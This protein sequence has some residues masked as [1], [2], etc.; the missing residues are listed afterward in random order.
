MI[1][2]SGDRLKADPGLPSTIAVDDKVLSALLG[3]L[4]DRNLRFPAVPVFV[5]DLDVFEMPDGLGFQFR[6]VEAPVILRGAKVAAVVRYLRSRLDGHSTIQRVL[7]DAPDEV[8]AR[9]LVRGLL[10]LHSKG[11][12]I[13]A[14]PEQALRINVADGNRDLLARER[15]YWQRHLGVTRSASSADEVARRVSAARLVVV[16]TGMFGAA[17]V[18]LL[19]RSGFHKCEVVAWNDD[20]VMQQSDADGLAG[21]FH[22]LRST[23]VD[24]AIP[25]LRDWLHG[26]DLVVTATCDAPAALFREVNEVCLDTRTPWLRANTDGSAFDIGP[27]VRPYE[28]SCYE[29]LAL[30]RQSAD[31]FAIETT[32]YQDRL[33]V[34]RD[35][36]S[37]VLVGEA[38]WPVTL[39]ASILVG[40]AF[41]FTSGLA[42]LTL[43]DAVLRVQPVTG[44]LERSEIRRVPRCPSCYRGDVPA[45]EIDT[46]SFASRGGVV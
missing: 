46:W 31:D 14:A 6:G 40:E 13:D 41:R 32:L 4:F 15:L 39:A 5:P 28:S 30:R 10:A 44:T 36:A 7:G 21:S 38:V 3:Q 20:G 34:E 35:A 45:A 23:S 22:R 33:A 43:T 8:P 16:G 26:P 27:F 37:R 17:T 2:G 24:E 42:P 1:P 29:C 11:L 12:L 9:A 19:V 18:D 25:V